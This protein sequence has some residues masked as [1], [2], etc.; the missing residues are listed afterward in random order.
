[1]LKRRRDWKLAMN[2]ANYIIYL[3]IFLLIIFLVIFLIV[4]L[5]IF[6]FNQSIHEFQNHFCIVK[7]C[8]AIQPSVV[9]PEVSALW[10]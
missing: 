9:R 6:L 8:H 2:L 5:I 3:I 10:D 4:Y 7:P 1:M